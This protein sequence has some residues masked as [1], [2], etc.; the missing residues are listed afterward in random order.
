M[1]F[2]YDLRYQQA[3]DS[4][5]YMHNRYK[6]CGFMDFITLDN[7][8]NFKMVKDILSAWQVGCHIHLSTDH[9]SKIM[10][11]GI[12]LRVEQGSMAVKLIK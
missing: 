12:K 5:I 8:N 9:Y 2:V 11:V 1:T 3:L 6:A 7:N 4:L 10:Y